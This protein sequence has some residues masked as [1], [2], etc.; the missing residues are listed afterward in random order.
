MLTLHPRIENSN[1]KRLF[2]VC[3][4]SHLE[5]FLSSRFGKTSCYLTAAGPVLFLKQTTFINGVDYLLV[6]EAIEEIAVVNEWNSLFIHNAMN[7]ELE[8]V[9]KLPGYFSKLIFRIVRRLFQLKIMKADV[10]NSPF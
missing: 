9:M 6:R 3:P 2:I 4:F 8:P 7:K 5:T 1:P 10:I